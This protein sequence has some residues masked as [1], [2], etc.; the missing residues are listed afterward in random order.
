MAHLIDWFRYH[1]WETGLVLI[2]FL[3]L[4]VASATAAYLKWN[5]ERK[6]QEGVEIVVT[7]TELRIG[8]SKYR[9]GL[10]AGLVAQDK[11]GV[12]GREYVEANF[13][14]GCR[15]GDKI[16]ARRVGVELIL[17]PAPCR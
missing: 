7:I 3:L 6:S 10:M 2:F 4:C 14:D 16:K 15:V 9:P 13:I 8:V 1:V 5:V 17:E 11:D 12:I